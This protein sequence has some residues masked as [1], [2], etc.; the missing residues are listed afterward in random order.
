MTQRYHVAIHLCAHTLMSYFRVHGVSEVN[1]SR[2]ARHLQHAPF[3]C[4]GIDL[5][6]RQIHFEGGQKLP[7]FLQLLRPFNQLPHPGDAL[8]VIFGG[9]FAAFVF[10]VSSDAFFRDTVHLLRA[11][12]HFKRLAAV[13]NGSMQGLIKVRARHGDVVFK[14]ARYRTPDV[15]HDPEGCV[16]ISLRIRN[17]ADSEQV[18]DLL[19][20]G[21]LPQNL[22][23]Q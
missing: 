19:E 18:I 23:M 13:Q 11:D 7:R 22:A 6:R 17:D 12:L 2:S 3:G 14:A 21:L 9:R 4:E 5:N 16:T 15:M 1:G 20:T 10:P 8:V